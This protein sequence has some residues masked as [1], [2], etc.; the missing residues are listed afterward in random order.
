MT[1]K[2]WSPDELKS[3]AE[4]YCASAEH[5]ESEV[6]L[7]LLQWR[8][9]A[10]TVD[11]IV[12]SLRVSGYVDDERYARAF[13]HDKV[14]FQGWGRVKIEY[15]LRAKKLPLPVIKSALKT[16]DE[17]EYFEQ[18]SHLLETKSFNALLLRGF[19]AEEIKQC[20]S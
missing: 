19:T 18:L 5:C 14:V 4:R 1:N 9:D 16:I 7:K 2:E 8:G 13:V 12:D 6:R 10:Q 3:K 11:K 20:Q 17:I 15:M